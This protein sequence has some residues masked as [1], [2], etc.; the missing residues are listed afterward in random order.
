MARIQ[1]EG[2]LLTVTFTGW[3]RIRS[4][5]RQIT[6][7][8][9]HISQVESLPDGRPSANSSSWAMLGPAARFPL[10]ARTSAFRDRD[11]PTLR[12]ARRH[13]NVVVL[14]LEREPLRRIIFEPPAGVP[15]DVCAA[16]IRVGASNA[17]AALPPI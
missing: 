16:R 8:L 13:R 15:A 4:R 3:S 10:L 6:V 17:H 2:G 1:I 7:P 11:G 5:S 14:I 12:V 9:A